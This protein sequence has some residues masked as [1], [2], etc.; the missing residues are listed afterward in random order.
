[1]SLDATD[2]ACRGWDG[3]AC[4]GTIHCPP[5]CP[6]FLD[7]DGE[8]WTVRPVT[9]VVTGNSDERS[10]DDLGSIDHP[11]AR[12]DAARLNDMYEAFGGRDRAQGLPPVSRD[13][14]IGWIESLLAEG[15]NV[16]AERDGRVLG[17]AA[18]TPADADRPEI[19]A[20]VHPEVQGLGVGTELCR[21]LI[22]DAAAGGREALVLH[23]AAG[24]RVARRVYRTVG[25]RTVD[26]G[27]DLRM[28]LP[29][30]EPVAT[31]V[32]W[33][34]IVREGSTAPANAE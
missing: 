34:P 25:F 13:R 31:E 23:V 8:R 5:R 30:D 26:R 22:A 3:G 24:N 4:E 7:K 28:E 10:P 16:V 19:A 27:G 11:I 29:L 14:R 15:R 12:V 1:M 33:P 32:R 6:R 20:F 2:V 17:H 18:Y 21:H 9:P